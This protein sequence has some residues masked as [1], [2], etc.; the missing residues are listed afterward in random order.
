MNES[1]R[2]W[3]RET[4][5]LV[6]KSQAVAHDDGNGQSYLFA[7]VANTVDTEQAGEAQAKLLDVTREVVQRACQQ[8]IK[9]KEI[10]AHEEIGDERV[11]GTG[12]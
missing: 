7:N 8:V 9:E 12:H 4:E 1:G 11:G 6:V 3:W 2:R 5:K 10:A